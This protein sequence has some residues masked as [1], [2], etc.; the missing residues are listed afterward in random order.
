[1]EHVDTN[2]VMSMKSCITMPYAISPILMVV[3]S[4]KS[5]ITMPYLQLPLPKS[6]LISAQPAARDA[7]G[8]CL[9]LC[10]GVVST[11]TTT[12][13]SAHYKT[14]EITTWSSFGRCGSCT[15]AC[16]GACTGTWRNPGRPRLAQKSGQRATGKQGQGYREGHAGACQKG[17]QGQSEKRRGAT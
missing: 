6:T 17:G 4:M 11:F 13:R 2:G 14:Y 5:R 7:S 3:M 1:M 12:R 15:G 8:S 10:S 16:T 9:C